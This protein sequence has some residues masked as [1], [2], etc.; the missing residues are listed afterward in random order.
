MENIF[1][2][3]IKTALYAGVGAVALV[4]EKSAELIGELA[5]IGESTVEQG[6]AVNEELKQAV[7][8]CAQ[9]IEKKK[10]EAK[11]NDVLTKIETMSEAERQAV[12][13][14]LQEFDTQ[15]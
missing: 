13:A 8:D 5:S 1:T 12:K 3:S 7:K 6:K 15:G 10:A 2:D 9:D 11:V 14:K 4:V